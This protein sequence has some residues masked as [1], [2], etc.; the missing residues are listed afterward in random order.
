M[1]VYIARPQNLPQQKV[2][3]VKFTPAGYRIENDRW[4]QPVAV[5]SYK[6]RKPGPPIISQMQV[7]TEIS[8]IRYFIYPERC[9]S[10]SDIPGDIKQEYTS[11]EGK[12]RI[13]NPYIRDLAAEIVGDEKNPYWMARHIF[14]YVRHSLEYKLEGGWN[15]APVVLQRGTGSCSEYT[16]SFIAL[17]RAAGIPARYVGAIVVRGDDASFDRVFHRWPEVYLPS[18]GWIPMDPQG[19]DKERPADRAR[20]IGHLSNRFLIT[21]CGGGDSDFLGWYYNYNES[22]QTDPQVL[23]NIETFGEWEPVIDY[24]EGEQHGNDE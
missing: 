11:D 7:E 21:T 6:D 12:Y 22:Y 1:E 17:C 23:V 13:I 19:G 15:I 16:F 8:S 2:T 10:L 18:Y 24:K 9:G 3:E 5:F 4:D 20:Y 14:D